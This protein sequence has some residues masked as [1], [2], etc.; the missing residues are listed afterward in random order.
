MSDLPSVE[1]V[2]EWVPD[3]VNT[4]LRS[5]L[6]KFLRVQDFKKIEDNWVS[7]PVLLRLT[8]E[9]L[10]AFPYEL[11]GGPADAVAELVS[12]IKG[13]RQEHLR[14]NEDSSYF[15]ALNMF[16][17]EPELIPPRTNLLEYIQQPFIKPIEVHPTNYKD[18]FQS[19]LDPGILDKFFVSSP[20]ASGRLWT[21]YITQIPCPP[22]FSSTKVSF[23]SFWD[24]LIFKPF[25]IA[26]P[27]G[28]FNRNSNCHAF[29]KKFRPD[30][31]YLVENACLVR[32]EEKGPNNDDDP[33][34]ELISKLT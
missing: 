20:N 24:A 32:G 26:Y 14:E 10:L 31:S 16:K 15:S 19:K 6:K 25:T 17:T 21:E 7:G 33:A 28:N 23:Y 27:F 34:I 9:K 4:F 2:N 1:E 12:K 8:L 29:T 22:R 5:K 11:P 18:Y 3:V 13:E 30:F